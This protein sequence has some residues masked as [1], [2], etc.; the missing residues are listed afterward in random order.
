MNNTSITFYL[1]SEFKS[2]WENL[3]KDKLI[4]G[5]ESLYDNFFWL[6]HI[7]QD[8]MKCV[9]EESNNVIRNKIKE[10]LNLFNIK[11]ENIEKY[12][13]QFRNF[14]QE[15][16][17]SIFI[18]TDDFLIKI[19]E[20]LLTITKEYKDFPLI[21]ELESDL[22]S[23]SFKIMIQT[24]FKL[25]M[26]MLLH[27]PLLTLK[28]E[29]YQTREI[30]Y[31]FYEKGEYINIDGFEKSK[32]PCVV[33]LSAPLL[34]NNYPYQGIKPAV[35]IIPNPTDTIKQ[36][37]SKNS[38]TTPKKAKTSLSAKI[39]F[40]VEKEPLEV[41]SKTDK[42][43]SLDSPKKIKNNDITMNSNH[44]TIDCIV[45]TEALSYYTC[46][47]EMMLMKKESIFKEK[48]SVSIEEENDKI[49]INESKYLLIQD[50]D[51]NNEFC[52]KI[53]NTE[54]RA[55]QRCLDKPLSMD[56]KLISEYSSILL[57]NLKNNL[58]SLRETSTK[59]NRCYDSNLSKSKQH[60]NLDNFTSTNLSSNNNPTET[61]P[62]S[63]TKN[64]PCSVLR[65]CE[66]NKI[67]YPLKISTVNSTSNNN[68]NIFTMKEYK[69]NVNFFN[70]IQDKKEGKY[71]LLCR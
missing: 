47:N 6:S 24:S 30:K 39:N 10:M 60:K 42:N 32:T 31:L 13:D 59:S 29:P 41:V 40:T 26:Y 34:R 46:P 27:D 19:K 37:C 2:N 65:L 43:L 54:E 3:L 66:A 38:S 36:E 21:N 4:D 71:N 53:K 44:K 70:K 25:T 17:F 16:F 55:Y 9:Y 61:M 7:V 62:G 64:F 35:L 12:L 11:D 8:T 33:I 69:N 49:L 45:H 14:F 22:Q 67:N 1:P 48:D 52:T 5:F 23:K 20:S 58:Q 51:L 50:L 56:K 57:Q 68:N 63:R 15:H 18:F 28:I